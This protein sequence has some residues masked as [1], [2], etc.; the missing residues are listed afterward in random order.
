MMSNLVI[1]LSSFLV[2][3]NNGPTYTVEK[4][5]D[6]YEVRRYDQWI[7]AETVV[8]GTIENAGNQAFHILAGY[9]FGSNDQNVKIEMTAPVIQQ[10]LG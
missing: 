4:K 6:N 1:L 2:F 10:Q 9:I 3:N 7:V 8:S 5:V